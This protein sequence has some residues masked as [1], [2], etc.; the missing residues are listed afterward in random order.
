MKKF[1]SKAEEK[2]RQGQGFG[3]E[4]RKE[5]GEVT[6]KVDPHQQQKYNA[7]EGEYVD[8]EEIKD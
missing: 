6:V 4:Q 3:K 1:L 8:F 2:M 7:N 5:E